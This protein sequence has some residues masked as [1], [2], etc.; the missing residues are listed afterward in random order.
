MW[1]RKI[2][3]IQSVHIENLEHMNLIFMKITELNISKKIFHEQLI[4]YNKFFLSDVELIKVQIRK[5]NPWYW[6][7]YLYIVD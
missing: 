1:R 4:I 2:I 5:K 6:L 3:V 7:S